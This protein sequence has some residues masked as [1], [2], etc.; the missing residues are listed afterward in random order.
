[1]NNISYINFALALKDIL[2]RCPKV[3]HDR[4][5][6]QRALLKKNE[7]NIFLMMFSNTFTKYLGITCTFFSFRKQ[8]GIII[9][10]F[11]TRVIFSLSSNVCNDFFVASINLGQHSLI[12]IQNTQIF[13]YNEMCISTIDSASRIINL[14]YFLQFNIAQCCAYCDL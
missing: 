1:M 11:V 9:I 13:P 6:L 10:Y 3:I 2:D 5:K 8:T 14:S 7:S 4:M 12:Y